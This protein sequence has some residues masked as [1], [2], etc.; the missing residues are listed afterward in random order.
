MTESL[1]DWIDAPRKSFLYLL[2]FQTCCYGFSSILYTLT[3]KTWEYKYSYLQISLESLKLKV[4]KLSYRGHILFVLKTGH[5]MYLIFWT[6]YFSKYHVF[7]GHPHIRWQKNYHFQQWG[8]RRKLPIFV[9]ADMLMRPYIL[10]IN[11]LCIWCMV[12]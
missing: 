4:K 2:L 1:T 5:Y 3:F 8:K 6:R 12:A 9:S 7:R 10:I 11:I